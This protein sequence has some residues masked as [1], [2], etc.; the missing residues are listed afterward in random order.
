[1][2][3][4]PI[5]IALAVGVAVS[6]MAYFGGPALAKARAGRLA[7]LVGLVALPLLLSIGNLS[8][9]FHES[10]QT[11]FCLSCHEMRRHGESLFVDDEHALAAT[12]YQNRFIERDTVCYSCHKDYA[13]FGDARAKLNGL[14]HVW[15]HYVTGVPAKLALYAPYSSANCLH[16]HDDARRFREQPA[17]QPVLDELTSGSRSCLSCHQVAH[18]MAKVEARQLWQAR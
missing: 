16:C 1:M 2:L 11:T 9:G 18:D 10:S 6:V 4:V 17:H 3:P 15:A 14:R 5:I 12:H 7:L 13:L 8:Y